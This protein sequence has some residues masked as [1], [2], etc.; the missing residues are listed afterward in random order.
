ML[1]QLADQGWQI[2]YFSA[3]DEVRTFLE[4]QRQ[5]VTIIEVEKR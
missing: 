4:K 1:L 3:K 2:I 5:P